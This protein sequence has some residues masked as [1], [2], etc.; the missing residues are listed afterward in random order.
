MSGGLLIA[1]VQVKSVKLAVTESPG[2]RG[3]GWTVGSVIGIV[4]ALLFVGDIPNL[5]VSFKYL[6]SNLAR[7]R[8]R[9]SR[10]R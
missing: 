7:A 3:I 10:T 8:F 5:A 2:S 9:T 4:V 6:R 1:R